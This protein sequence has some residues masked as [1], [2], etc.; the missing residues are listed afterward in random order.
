MSGKEINRRNFL[1]VMGWSGAGAATLSGC[2]LPTTVTI[3]EGKE[4]VVSYLTPEEYVI[5]GQGVWFASTCT[6][7][8]AACGVYGRVRE[9]R[10]LK[11]EGNPES[12]I[13]NGK[14]CGMGQASLQ[15][16]YNPDRL[17]KP[18]MR[19]GT[20]LQEVT[21]DEALSFI[22]SKVG[23]KSGIKG[24][25]VAWLTGTVSGHQAVLLQAH[26]D[27]YGSIS[28]YVHEIVNT[29]V[30][31]VANKDV[32]GEVQPTYHLNKAKSVLSLGADFLGASASPVHFATQYSEFRDAPRGVLIQVE[33]S[34]SLTGANADLW[35]PARPG[36]EG[37]LALG[38]ANALIASHGV[39]ADV[40]PAA[41]RQSI[42]KHTAD[43]TAE[44]SGVS[45]EQI[46]AI[47]KTLKER[48]PSLV[49]SGAS[50]E[51]HAHGYQVA[52]AAL[53]LNVLLGN[54]GSTITSAGDFAFPQLRARTGNTR[55]LFAFAE[56]ADKGAFDVVFITGTN[57][58]YTA[59]SFLK[60]EDKLAKV[61]VK[62]AFSM[63]RDETVAKA[64]VV[65]PLASSYEDWGT[66][67]AAYAGAS[68]AISIQQPIMEK[69]YPETRGFGDSLLSLLK[70]RDSDSYGKFND[71]Y[72]Y[73]RN[74]FKEL[75]AS[76]KGNISDDALWVQGL[77][78]AS[79]SIQPQTKKLT[80]AAVPVEF[81]A[82]DKDSSFPMH[83]APAARMGMWD[84]RNA[85]LP[86][87]Q[88]QPDQ[89]SKVVWGSWAELH[90][91]TADKLGLK[92]G[93]FVSV[94]S[95]QGSV[96]VPV[97]I[98]RGVHPDVVA[99]PIGQG[100]TDYGRYAT[101]RGVN[102]LKILANVTDAK[103]GELG[104]YATRV[105]VTKVEKKKPGINE[106]MVRFGGSDT[107]IG[108]K[109]VAS[110]SADAF[111]RTEGA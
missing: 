57:P 62:V 25:R 110:V 60:L 63:F 13:G 106:V 18:L 2:D 89:L 19:K 24:N 94:A 65:L 98:Y 92:E 8:S 109:L 15:A 17:K 42:D 72:A 28:H 32:L 53:M 78:K 40:L 43:R 66:H 70:L 45:K 84:G 74:A 102:P 36:T 95:A 54:V 59:P 104:L 90:P 39:S 111:N 108:R 26:L 20:E 71:Y 101:G 7:C 103:T 83:L 35:V 58:V 79:I 14:L 49:L 67:V 51:G 81:P 107:Q 30:S 44:I 23:A 47:A 68:P 96:E 12:S 73:L 3:E 48:S 55:D 82:Y 5:P 100:H 105:S 21:W 91:K 1:K 11:V 29:A 61:P 6:Q 85:N 16:H 27:S 38:I 50:A 46:A 41:L 56:G 75:P 34:M 37:V 93:D 76:A 87:L 10:L 4:A 9:G 97:Y 31:S 52:A 69:L 64:D 99:V 33:P 77:Q 86:W 22:D 88:E 80:T